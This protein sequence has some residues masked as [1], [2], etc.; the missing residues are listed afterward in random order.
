MKTANA[1]ILL[2]F[3]I[4]SVSINAQHIITGNFPPLAGQQVR[5][6][7]FEGFG[8]YTID[9]TKVSEQ[10]IFTLS[11]ADKDQGMGYLAAEDNKAYF[12]VLDNENIQLKGEMLSVPESVVTLSGKEN[13]LFVQYATDHPKREQALSAWVYLQN[14]YRGD[15]LFAIQKNPKKTIETEMQH[16]KQEDLDFLNHLDTN[17]YISWYLPT[18]KLVSSVSTVA[19]YRTEEITETLAAFRKLDYTDER[20]YKSG[21]LKDAIESHFWLLENMGQPLDSVYIEMSI[22]IDF[23]LTN[24]SGNEKKFNEITKYIFELLERQSLLKAS[25]YL[26]IKV[27]TQNSCTVNDDLAKQLELY[28]AMKKGNTVPDIVFSGDIFKSG[29]LIKT[30]NRFSDIHSAYK[31]VIFGASWCPKCAEELRQLLPLYEKWKSKGIEV[32]FISLDTDNAVFRNFTSIFPFI[33]MCDYK[34]WDM[35]A[36]KDYYVFATPTM[37]LLDN[38]QKIILRPNS[39]K[40]IDAWVDYSIGEIKQ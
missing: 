35:Q 24:L 15:S 37:F 19:Q 31:V 8:I 32:V 40:Q 16:I 20:L 10:G 38:N 17:S 12:V 26:S 36:V 5:L 11:Y 21:L 29:S 13:K 14:F 2:I 33:S 34:K 27:L 25:E 3:S 30:P 23:M 6:V 9:S 4:L 18:R 39:V 7:G 1:F 22:S 28:R